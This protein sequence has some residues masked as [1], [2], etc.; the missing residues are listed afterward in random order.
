MNGKLARDG[1]VWN[2]RKEIYNHDGRLQLWHNVS[3]VLHSQTTQL[4]SHHCTYLAV[5]EGT[6]SL[7]GNQHR[8]PWGVRLFQGGTFWHPYTCLVVDGHLGLPV[9]HAHPS[10]GI[11]FDTGVLHEPPSVGINFDTG[12]L[13]Q[14]GFVWLQSHQAHGNPVTYGEFKSLS[15]LANNSCVPQ[16]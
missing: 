12:S 16:Q 4:S 1:R 10:V 3:K 2:T 8:R 11:N 15:F 6:P 14:A 13:P 7:Y 5:L 9:L